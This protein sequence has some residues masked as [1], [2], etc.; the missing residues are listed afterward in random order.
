LD[1]PPAKYMHEDERGIIMDLKVGKDWSVTFITFKKGA[2]RGN[3]YHNFTKQIDIILAG[4]LEVRLENL[5]MKKDR[6]DVV[7]IEPG[8]PHAYQ[9]LEDSAMLSICL[10]KRIGENYAKDTFKTKCPLI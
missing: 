9:A 10:G 1:N 3:H 6:G 4:V 7:Q 5:I 8:E 2:I